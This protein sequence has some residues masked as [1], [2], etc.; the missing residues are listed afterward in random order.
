VR[1]TKNISLGSTIASDSL[2]IINI[3]KRER[4]ADAIYDPWIA[5]GRK[6]TKSLTKGEVVHFSDALSPDL[7][8]ASHRN[9]ILKMQ[10]DYSTRV[11]DPNRRPSVLIPVLRS[12]HDI[13]AGATISAADL[14]TDK[15]KEK[16]CP[17]DAVGDLWVVVGRKAVHSIKAHQYV[18]YLDTIPTAE[19]LQWLNNGW[20]GSKKCDMP[21]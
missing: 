21:K 3:D 1:C 16:N 5:I 8:V 12:A 19:W 18:I 17:G 10:G 7:L 4:P 2:K 13:P 20:N 14:V 6:A 15:I 11:E 9:G